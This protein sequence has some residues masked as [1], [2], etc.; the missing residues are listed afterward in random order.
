[1]LLERVGGERGEEK[2]ISKKG[3]KW[4]YYIAAQQQH[5]FDF[6]KKKKGIWI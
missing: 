2:G 4:V 5:H 6:I 3:L 1:M